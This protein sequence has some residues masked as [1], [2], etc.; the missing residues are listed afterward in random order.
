M[1][2]ER[3]FFTLLTSGSVSAEP[4]TFALPVHVAAAAVTRTWWSGAGRLSI[5]GGDRG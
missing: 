3:H 1:S 2:D 5:R 4:L